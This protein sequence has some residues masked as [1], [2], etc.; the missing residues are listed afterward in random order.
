M[1][2]NTQYLTLDRIANY[3]IKVPGYIE[4]AWL[5]WNGGLTISVDTDAEGNQ[6]SVLTT[7]VDQAG[8]HGLLGHLYA[9][10]L[11]LISVVLTG[12]GA[13]ADSSS[14]DDPSQQEDRGS[15]RR[16]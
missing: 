6:I 5:D 7:R 12:Y 10:G 16:D 14:R 1:D 13:S 8:L 9:L 15:P 4:K 2:G 3:Q 11:P